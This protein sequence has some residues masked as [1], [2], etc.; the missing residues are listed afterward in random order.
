MRLGFDK[1]LYRLG[2][3]IELVVDIHPHVA[4][5]IDDT[6]V[7]LICEMESSTGPQRLFVKTRRLDR[8]EHLRRGRPV[9][10]VCGLGLPARKP[11]GAREPDLSVMARL[12]RRQLEDDAPL[13][14]KDL[15][16][17]PV[18]LRE[19]A[20]ATTRQMT[21]RV[22][23]VLSENGRVWTQCGE[24]APVEGFG[25]GRASAADGATRAA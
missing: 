17:L 3:Q 25:D 12:M 15:A 7:R 1:P 16:G 20:E 21:W 11:G 9:R 22:E 5:R 14:V 6:C 2:D 4:A 23:V 19:G 13:G 10:L 8:E 18:A 24:I